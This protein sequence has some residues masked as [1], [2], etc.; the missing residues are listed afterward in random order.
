MGAVRF[1]IAATSRKE[2]ERHVQPAPHLGRLRQ[3]TS[4]LAILAVSEGQRL[5]PGALVLR[6]HEKTVATW[7]RECCCYG[8]PGA[9]PPTPTGRPSNLTPTHKAARMTL[10]D[11]GPVHAGCSGACWRSPMIQPR[12]GARCGVYDSVCYL[13]PLRKNYGLS[14]QQ[15]AFVS[16]PRDAGKRHAWRTTTWPQMLR[17]AQ[18]R[19]GAAAL[20]R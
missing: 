17:L 8:L 18:E 11:A 16:A 6:V 14:D 15:A 4:Y 12:I 19:K 7:R 13:A 20:W 1:P 3:T 9:P 2:V 10:R 5:T